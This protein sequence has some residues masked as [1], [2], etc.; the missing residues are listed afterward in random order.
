VI[1]PTGIYPQAQTI[2][3]QWNF[4]AEDYFKEF[5][6]I[7]DA[8]QRLNLKDFQRLII[9]SRLLDGGS[10]FILQS[11]SQLFPIEDE[12]ISSP[13][14]WKHE[15]NSM[16]EGIEVGS[17][18]IIAAYHICPRDKNGNVDPSQAKRIPAKNFI[19][20]HKS[21]RF[22]MERGIPEIAPIIPVLR[23]LS[24]LM[25]ATISKAKL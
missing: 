14:D 5:A 3:P 12:R 23:D 25:Q 18:G 7:I 9:I 15:F 20:C 16:V 1:G 11:N 21:T 10:G 13:K 6:K 4:L 8:R 2:D 24:E 17:N 22:D 19:Y